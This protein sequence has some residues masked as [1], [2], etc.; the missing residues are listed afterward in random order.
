QRLR[1]L[2]ASSPLQGVVQPAATPGHAPRVPSRHVAFLPQAL[3]LGL[4]GSPRPGR[5]AGDPAAVRSGAWS[6][7]GPRPPDRQPLTRDAL[8]RVR[9]ITVLGLLA[10]GASI[11]P[12]A[13]L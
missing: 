9:E 11:P 13:Q 2:V 4:A 5:L 10:R 12:G 1:P 3:R 8:A 7:C 6:Q